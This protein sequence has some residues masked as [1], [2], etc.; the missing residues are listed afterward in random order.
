MERF[1]LFGSILFSL[2]AVACASPPSHSP[3]FVVAIESAHTQLDPRLAT[4]AY[5]ERIG[6]L[7]FSRLVRINSS[8]EITPDLAKKWEIKRETIYIF[9]L[10]EGV[11][12]HDGTPLT[13]EDVRYTY[14]SILD[15]A[16][17]S[18]HR[19]L[20][21]VIDRI[22]TPD[23]ATVRF[24]LKKPHAP[25]LYSLTRGIVPKYAAANPAFSMHPIG[26][27]PFQF[28]RNDPDHAIEL[29]AYSNYFGGA[30]RISRLLFRIIPEESV[31]L[32]ELEKGNIDLIQNAFP[33]D[34][35][36]R[37]ERNRRFKIM[38]TPGTTYSYVGFNL[39]DSILQDT[40]VR[41]AIALAINREEIAKYIFK[42][43]VRPATGLLPSSHWA[44][45]HQVKTYLY[46]P[47]GARKLLDEAGYLAHSGPRFTLTH[48]TSQNELARRV[49]E[50]LQ[51]QL[52]EIGIKVDIR[53]HEWGTFY[54]DIKRGNFQMFTLSWVGIEDP[55][56]YYNLFHSQSVPPDGSNRGYYQNTAIDQLVEKGRLTFDRTL[57]KMVYANVQKI[58]SEE[59]PYVSLW[60]AENVAVMKK[61]VQGYT[62]Y[63]DGGFYSLKDVYWDG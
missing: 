57:R 10:K 37:L 55:D 23:A 58:L 21:D 18:S 8:G 26:S 12:F 39:R 34:V 16:L 6:Q 3:P 31:R 29:S 43:L 51:Q 56:I 32:L 46:D 45:S 59:L 28:V 35:L 36:P 60:H 27:G 15:A 53:S 62:L 49:V 38:H 1:S 47:E 50:V 17:A 52:A 13:S 41:K 22:E 9:R 25:F 42:G 33:P 14:E 48:K 4:D 11:F 7:L 19:K 54:G 5:S 61:E 30:P 40:K 20:Y 44:Y 24:I 2:L 63:P